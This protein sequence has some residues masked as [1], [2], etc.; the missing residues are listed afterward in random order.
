MRGI[1][2][3]AH[4]PPTMVSLDS[5]VQDA[6]RSMVHNRVGAVAVVEEGRLRGIFTERDLMV[7]V[8]AYG[9]D[10]RSTPLQEV[11]TSRVDPLPQDASPGDALRS[12]RDRHYRHMPVCEEDG[13]VLG[14]LSIRHL[15]QQRL[16]N[17]VEEVDSLEAFLTADGSGG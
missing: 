10:P 15:L 2:R 16:E 11:M 7:K 1:L 9:L 14:I 5:S 8:V 12:M 17:L 6:V 13:T 4:T 3:I